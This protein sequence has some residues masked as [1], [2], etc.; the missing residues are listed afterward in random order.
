[1]YLT[2]FHFILAYSFSGSV[3]QSRITFNI[4]KW[5]LGLYTCRRFFFSIL[6]LFCFWKCALSSSTYSNR[7]R[8]L[9]VCLYPCPFCFRKKRLPEIVI[10][11]NVFYFFSLDFISSL[12]FVRSLVLVLF[13]YN[14]T[15]LLSS[16]WSC[17]IFCNSSADF[18]IRT[19]SSAK[20][21]LVTLSPSML[22]P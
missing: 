15:I 17:W 2:S 3:F 14:P 16:N 1:M 7:C 20:C 12:L 10:F 8:W 9:C 19:V 22:T 11:L 18:A 6:S 5:V 21:R 4:H 13:M